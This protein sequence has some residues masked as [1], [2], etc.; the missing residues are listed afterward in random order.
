[1][2]LKLTVVEICRRFHIIITSKSSS[3]SSYQC[4]ECRR[5]FSKFQ[6]FWWKERAKKSRGKRKG[7]DK[8][9][10]ILPTERESAVV[11][12]SRRITRHRIKMKRIKSNLR[13]NHNIR[14]SCCCTM[15]FSESLVR[16]SFGQLLVRV[17]ESQ[18][19][20]TATFS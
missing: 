1:M 11:E 2:R 13:E 17:N 16:D 15:K 9:K 5:I 8:G 19:Y 18:C 7:N 10:T 6:R 3:L 14:H 12:N 4:K 20:L